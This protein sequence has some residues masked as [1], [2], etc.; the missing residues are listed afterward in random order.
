M[1]DATESSRLHLSYTK[2][3]SLN[4]ALLDGDLAPWQEPKIS[5]IGTNDHFELRTRRTVPK[6]NCAVRK[7]NCAHNVDTASSSTTEL[8][9][10]PE[11]SG[12][13]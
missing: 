5:S 9:A 2:I 13:V 8:G 12:V 11:K 10:T 1:Y 3:C 6:A 4:H 7:E